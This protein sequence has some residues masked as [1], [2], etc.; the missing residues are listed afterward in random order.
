MSEPHKIGRTAS[1]AQVP[2][3]S[4]ADLQNLQRQKEQARLTPEQQEVL[5]EAQKVMAEMEGVPKLKGTIEGLMG[6]WIEAQMDLGQQFNDLVQK[7]SST[8]EGKKLSPKDFEE[9]Y[10]KCYAYHLALNRQST[11]S[12][13]DFVE[14]VQEAGKAMTDHFEQLREKVHGKAFVQMQEERRSNNAMNWAA[15]GLHQRRWKYQQEMVDA[16]NELASL[17]QEQEIERTGTLEGQP[18]DVEGGFSQ[19]QQQQQQE[20]LKVGGLGWLF[21]RNNVTEEEK[22]EFTVR[23]ADTKHVVHPLARAKKRGA[24][25][26]L[27]QFYSNP[28]LVHLFEVPQTMA[29]M[30]Y[31]YAK[32]F[33]EGEM[34]ANELTLQRLRQYRQ[35]KGNTS[36]LTDWYGELVVNM[37]ELAWSMARH[38][39]T[40]YMFPSALQETPFGWTEEQLRERWRVEMDDQTRLRLLEDP[41][42]SYHDYHNIYYNNLLEQGMSEEMAEKYLQNQYAIYK[43]HKEEL[44]PKEQWQAKYFAARGGVQQNEA[45]VTRAMEAADRAYAN[46]MRRIKNPMFH[47]WKSLFIKAHNL[48]R[49]DVVFNDGEYSFYVDY[50]ES[51]YLMDAHGAYVKDQ[52]GNYILQKEYDPSSRLMT[53][54]GM[55]SM[56]TDVLQNIIAATLV[57]K[58]GLKESEDDKVAYNAEKEEFYKVTSAQMSQIAVEKAMAELKQNIPANK[59]ITQLVRLLEKAKQQTGLY[60][61]AAAALLAYNQFGMSAEATEK[62][63]A[64]TL[65]SIRQ[66]IQAKPELQSTMTRTVRNLLRNLVDEEGQIV[67]ST[68]A[69]RG[70]PF[71]TAIRKYVNRYPQAT[72]YELLGFTRANLSKIEAG[73]FDPQEM[74]NID[75]TALAQ[76]GAAPMDVE[77]EEALSKV[78]IF[79]GANIL[80]DPDMVK[81]NRFNDIR[82]G[83]E[84]RIDHLIERNGE[85]TQNLENQIKQGQIIR[86]AEKAFEKRKDSFAKNLGIQILLR[87]WVGKVG[88]L[89]GDLLSSAADVQFVNALINAPYVHGFLGYIITSLNL[90]G[91]VA[92]EQAVSAVVQGLLGYLNM[93]PGVGLLSGVT[94]TVE[95]VGG[96]ISSLGSIPFLGFLPNVVDNLGSI[97]GDNPEAVLALILIIAF[98]KFGSRFI[99][100]PVILQYFTNVFEVHIRSSFGALASLAKCLG[101]SLFTGSFVDDIANAG[102][103]IS[104]KVVY[105]LAYIGKSIQQSMSDSNRPE[106]EEKR[107]RKNFAEKWQKRATFVLSS[108]A[109]PASASCK[110]LIRAAMLYT[111]TQMF[112]QMMDW[113]NLIGPS[114]LGINVGTAGLALGVPL[115][116][117]FVQGGM[118]A[119]IKKYY[120]AHALMTR[121]I[122][123]PGGPKEYVVDTAKVEEGK[124]VYTFRNRYKRF[125]LVNAVARTIIQNPYLCIA[126]LWVMQNLYAKQ[127]VEEGTPQ[128]RTIEY[129]TENKRENEFLNTNFDNIEG[130]E[131]HQKQIGN[132]LQTAKEAGLVND[133]CPSVD[134]FST[135]LPG[136]APALQTFFCP[137]VPEGVSRELVLKMRKE[138]LYILGN[139]Q[140][141]LELIANHPQQDVK[142][143]AV[144]IL[145]SLLDQLP[146]ME[147]MQE[148]AAAAVTTFMATQNPVEELA[149]GVE[150]MLEE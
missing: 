20:P 130:S 105:Y 66:S 107:E 120:T 122:P 141:A 11:Q 26:I 47:E 112:L 67:K 52:R 148:D 38:V 150:G 91:G 65:E 37:G 23:D 59:R 77:S 39:E 54:R 114:V 101:V 142:E 87:N 18:M 83:L 97:L 89:F 126:P 60:P 51:T 79:L 119:M 19:Q 123:C 98:I 88:P 50:P 132:L 29:K 125:N 12:D 124:V 106:G 137:V 129:K 109:I 134:T 76:L 63:I 108:V 4:F 102:V 143:R 136:D 74:E 25:T 147:D 149:R 49:E 73:A 24:S 82:T 56:V 30:H 118:E 115:G 8:P 48:R 22:K 15:T 53:K 95:F 71:V 69:L 2:K 81:Y 93:I 121:G 117:A 70:S 7:V 75:Q 1:I 104:S 131:Y 146:L 85:L 42:L 138:Q 128:E 133:N 35:E 58:Q 5:L 94:S 45:Q 111:T 110:L 96:L 28:F 16:T 100:L 127:S 92:E 61:E 14:S 64:S 80:G 99:Q 145:T 139:A 72:D 135:R 55:L 17:L 27:K 86:E 10:K 21:G 113:T 40:V 116:L 13:Q 6:T 68:P 84:S 44:L 144:N 3:T 9:G 33:A 140:V 31:A 62:A 43:V 78:Y 32:S 36:A 57:V 90:A 103:L 34:P 46:A 41:L